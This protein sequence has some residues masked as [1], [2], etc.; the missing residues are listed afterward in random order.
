MLNL[1]TE[2]WFEFYLPSLHTLQSEVILGISGFMY[3]TTDTCFGL[4]RSQM[5]IH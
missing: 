2:S 3:K 5:F 4:E 1:N